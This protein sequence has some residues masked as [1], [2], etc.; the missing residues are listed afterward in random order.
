MPDLE[1]SRKSHT[2]KTMLKQYFGTAL[3]IIYCKIYR[4]E[5]FACCKIITNLLKGHVYTKTLALNNGKKSH[6]T[7]IKIKKLQMMYCK[8]TTDSR[9]T[10]R[11]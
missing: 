10:V 9:H 6:C 11:I 2:T 1:H 5:E 7:F 4:G 3:L 8:M